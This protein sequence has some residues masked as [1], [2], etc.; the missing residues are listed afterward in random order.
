MTLESKRETPRS[1]VRTLPDDLP[2]EVVVEHVLPLDCGELI[3]DELAHVGQI[4]R[5]V[6]WRFAEKNVTPSQENIQFTLP[7]L[8]VYVKVQ[9][10]MIFLPSIQA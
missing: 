10:Y 5:G 4:L 3:F 6:N 7:H 9:M 1:S 8:K 2:H